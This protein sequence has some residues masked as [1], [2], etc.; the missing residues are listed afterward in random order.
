M[1]AGFMQTVMP[2]N[3]IL[4]VK[5]EYALQ[6]I[7]G[8]KTVELRRK[9]PLEGVI[10]GVA[11]IYA[12]SPVQEIVG[13]ARIH[14]VLKLPVASIWKKFEKEACVT[15][16]FFNSYFRELDE[17]FAITLNDAVKLETPLG[18]KTLEKKYDFSAPQSYRYASQKILNVV[19]I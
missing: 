17:G 12:S 7:E 13:Y 1:L 14:S 9:F 11:I 18:I 10:G 16:K 2:K 19:E 3:F 6:I 5:P 15:R 8:K 4:S